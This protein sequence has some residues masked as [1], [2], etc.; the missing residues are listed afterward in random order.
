MLAYIVKHMDFII[1]DHMNSGEQD[2]CLT[3]ANKLLTTMTVE[4]INQQQMIGRFIRRIE[5]KYR[6]YDGLKTL[7]AV[8]LA[9]IKHNKV[10]NKKV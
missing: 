3:M 9:K 5:N 4:T 8:H 10:I 1:E 6:K 7:K 2:S